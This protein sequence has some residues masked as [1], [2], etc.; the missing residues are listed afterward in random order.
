MMYK[1]SKQGK[2]LMASITISKLSCIFDNA[3]IFTLGTTVVE[4]TRL[5][6]L[7]KHRIQRVSKVII[8]KDI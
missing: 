5:D 8:G 7:G 3:K 4:L 6:P 1:F 2:H